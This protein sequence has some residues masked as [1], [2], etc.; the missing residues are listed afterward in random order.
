MRT[1]GANMAAGLRQKPGIR[2]ALLAGNL[3]LIA[4]VAWWSPIEQTLGPRIRLVY[5]HGAWVW[6][7]LLTFAFAAAAGILG[8]VF[9]RSRW[10]GWSLALGRAGLFFWLTY[11]PMSLAVMQIFWGGLFLD[12]PR[13]RIPMMFGI[14]AVLLQLGLA[15]L[16]SNLLT[17]LANTSFFIALWWNL[18]RAENILHPDSPIFT[19][20]SIRIQIFFVVLVL[21][22]VLLGAQLAVWL[23]RSPAVH[24]DITKPTLL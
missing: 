12:E 15:F 3:L 11:L 4:M 9:R 21:L 1:S 14:V 5:F 19:S 17:C 10:P 6:A 22:C 23:R 13:W 7:G 20:D 16:N 2:T 24:T 18:S 8:L